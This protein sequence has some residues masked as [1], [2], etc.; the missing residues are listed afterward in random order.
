MWKLVIDDDEGKRTVVPL[1]REQYSIGR[2][3]GNTIRLTERNVSREHARLL[4][5]VN[6]SGDKPTFVLEDLTS[7]NGVFVNGLRITHS[8][9]LTHGDLVQIGDYHIVLQDEAVT[10]NVV[11]TVPIDVKQ[12]VPH[13]PAARA[14]ALLDRPN[15]LVMLAGPT[16]GQEYPLDQERL[17]IGRAEDASISVNHNSVSRLHCEVHALG[18]GRFEI[19]DKGSSN[20]VRLNGSDLRRGIVEPGDVI[21]LGD[22]KFKFIGAGQVFRPTE[23][24]Q[25]AAIANRDAELALA[26]SRR[27]A[28][29]PFAIFAGVV[30]IGG[31]IALVA[32]RAGGPSTPTSMQASL[33]SD[34]SV[35]D[36]AK[37]ACAAGDCETAHGKVG[38][39]GANSP[40]RQT[41]D[42]KDVENRWADQ[43]LARADAETDLARKR[44]L[45]Q[46]VATAPTVDATR[47]KIAADKI[48]GLDAVVTNPTQLPIATASTK[49]DDTVAMGHDAGRRTA[50]APDSQLPPSPG[51]TNPP[52]LTT[53]PPPLP[54][55]TTQPGPTTGGVTDKDRQ[56]ALQ[57]SPE[58][59]Q[60]LKQRLEQSVYSGKASETQIKLLIETCKQLGDR[61]CVS[62]ARQ[63]L[64]QKQQG[65]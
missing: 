42:F 17:T 25:L 48:Q 16:P 7:Y 58:A 43:V 39:I 12:T 52:P 63:Q 8:Q 60:L 15:R 49:P 54:P 47:R 59:K 32:A 62:Q 45:Y 38:A 28:A 46:R 31:A 44:D 40:L 4:K 2:K 50:L 14:A 34:Q 57:D 10:E 9:D 21:E 18:D 65:N 3:D 13:A 64:A 55:T 51:P 1:T 53:T 41:Q 24:Q 27:N 22:V 19:V 23:S 56:L 36:D 61:L 5:K 6:G 11:D 30:L 33:P 35:L 20:G 26:G 37:R 29:L